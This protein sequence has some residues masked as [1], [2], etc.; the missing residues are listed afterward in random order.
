MNAKMEMLMCA[1][2]LCF[3]ALALALAAAALALSLKGGERAGEPQEAD[4]GD[5][6]EPREQ[7]RVQEGIAN[8]LSYG[9]EELLGRRDDRC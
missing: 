2:A 6:A 5:E 4:A 8:I 1:L 9:M 7:R 3:S